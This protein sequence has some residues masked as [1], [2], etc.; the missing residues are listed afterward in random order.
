MHILTH[1]PFLCFASVIRFSLDCLEPTH[2]ADISIPLLS[3][4]LATLMSLFRFSDVASNVAVDDLTSLI[5][6]TAT[7]LLHPRFLAQSALDDAT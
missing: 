4:S 5:R 7:I 2:N 3:V 6:E 1:S